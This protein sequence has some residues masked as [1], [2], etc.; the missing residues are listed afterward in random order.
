M[1]AIITAIFA[2]LHGWFLFRVLRDRLTFRARLA[3]LGGGPVPGKI[4]ALEWIG[5][6]LNSVML[7][8]HITRLLTWNR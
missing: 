6:I 7:A 1:T 5:L 4:L 3:E 8:V 2:A